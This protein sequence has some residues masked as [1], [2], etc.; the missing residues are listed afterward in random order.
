MSPTSTRTPPPAPTGEQGTPPPPQRRELGHFARR[1]VVAVL[2]SLGFLALALILWTGIH[3]LMQAFAGVLFALFLTGLSEWVS[4]HT[5]LFYG[6]SLTVVVAG[7]FVLTG[8]LGW[9]LEAR[10][11]RQIEELSEKLPQSLKEV[12]DYIRQYSWGDKLLEQVPAPRKLF[13]RSMPSRG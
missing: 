7:L 3:V 9:F 6:W 4:K 10:L 11:V 2:I 12:Q 13:P 8:G 5:R 1:V